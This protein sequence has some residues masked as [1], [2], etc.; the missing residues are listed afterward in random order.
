M[1]ED[2]HQRSLQ[3]PV[4]VL[5]A[6]YEPINVTAV[7]RALVLIL[8][9]VATTEEEDGSFI[10]AARSQ[11]A[12]PPSSGCWNFGGFLIRRGPCLGRICFCVT[13]TPAS[14]VAGLSPRMNSRWIT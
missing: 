11:F 14:S 5:N 8:K 12:F 3:E 2:D 13:A 6:T 7:R 9:G 10:H 4:L 1:S